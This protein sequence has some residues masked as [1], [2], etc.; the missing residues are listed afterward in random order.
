MW[1]SLIE[2]HPANNLGK[3]SFS[4][5]SVGKGLHQVNV[6]SRIKLIE[7]LHYLLVESTEGTGE[8]LAPME[9]G[10]WLMSEG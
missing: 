3:L 4:Q 8:C 2:S 5:V 7:E 6:L 10:Q 9:D 1:Q